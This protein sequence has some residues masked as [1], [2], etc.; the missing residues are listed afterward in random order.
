[1]NA[2]TRSIEEMC[3]LREE[4][5]RPKPIVS[6]PQRAGLDQDLQRVLGQTLLTEQYGV[7]FLWLWQ[8][9]RFPLQFML[10]SLLLTADHQQ[11]ETTLSA[12]ASF[13]F[14]M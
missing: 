14:S 11:L 4:R 8:E 3:P 2:E 10:K 12:Q 5:R 1:M 9:L 6:Q 7:R 13:A